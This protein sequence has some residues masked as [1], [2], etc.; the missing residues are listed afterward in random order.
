MKP[1]RQIKRALKKITKISAFK[2]DPV[3]DFDRFWNIHH[4][5]F[6]TIYLTCKA[7]N[8]ACLALHNDFMYDYIPETIRRMSEIK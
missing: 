5:V 3:K 2:H 1:T 7:S 4:L 6:E 8:A